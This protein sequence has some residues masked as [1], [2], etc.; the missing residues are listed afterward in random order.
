MNIRNNN[1]ESAA[2]MNLSSSSGHS[3]EPVLTADAPS[4]DSHSGP[5]EPTLPNLRIIDVDSVGE[6]E[7][8]GFDPYNTA[9]LVK[10]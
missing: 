6:N 5:H 9:V 7:P 8:V 4:P 3:R 1:A 10:K 2:S